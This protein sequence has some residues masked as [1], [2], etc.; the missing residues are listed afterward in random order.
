MKKMF[1]AALCA[2]TAMSFADVLI[3]DFN[4]A[5]KTNA[6][7]L[8][9]EAYWY[10]YASNAT[11]NN[12]D[13][14]AKGW[15]MFR[16]D[17]EN[18]YAYMEGINGIKKGSDKDNPPVYSSVGIGLDFPAGV[19]LSGCT[20][21]TYKYK[22]AAHRFRAYVDGVTVDNGEEH[23]SADQT[24]ASDWTSATVTTMT[25]PSYASPQVTFAWNKVSKIAWVVDEKNTDGS[26]TSLMIDDVTCVGGTV[27]E[28]S[29]STTTTTSSTAVDVDNFDDGNTTAEALGSTAYWYI[30]TSNGGEVGNTQDANQSW[31][32]I[33]KDGEN[34]YAAMKQIKGITSGDTKYPSVGMEVAFDMGVLSGCTA[35]QYDYKGS[36]HHMRASVDGV[37]ADKGYEHVAID[38]SASTDWKTV[39]VSTMTQPSWVNSKDGD[40]ASVQPFSWAKVSKFAWVVDEKLTAA[41]IGTELAI[42]NVKCV[43]TL[44][45]AT[46]TS[47]NSNTDSSDSKSDKDKSDAIGTMASVSGL[48]ATIHGNT[49]QVSVAKAGLVKVQVFDMMGH[50]IESHSENMTAG[51]FAHSFGNMSKGAYIIR[52]QQGSMMKTIRMQVR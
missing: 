45:T 14:G 37:K 29:S 12:K 24:T 46:P 48:N 16:K 3:D 8:G 49:L 35:L 7:G 38:Q 27:G 30:Y 20:S 1:L 28:G 17:G 5:E 26:S 32:L 31:D 11:L 23:V 36:G 9:A 50:A 22:G 33:V 44:G 13:N 18:G 6:E 47:S 41:N 10:L 51:S 42:D 19:A 34:S 15:D 4:D 52:V 25:Q 39:T 21:L 43:G 2:T 40:P